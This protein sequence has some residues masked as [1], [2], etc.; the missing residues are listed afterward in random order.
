MGLGYKTG[1]LQQFIT[2]PRSH[3][4]LKPT[5]ISLEEAATISHRYTAIMVAL[6][7]KDGLDLPLEPTEEDKKKGVIV[8]GAA[9]GSGMFAV[10]I[11]KALGYQTILAVASPKQH[12]KLLK[13]GATEVFDR[14]DADLASK[15]QPKYPKLHLGLVAQI[16]PAGWQTMLDILKSTPEH[17]KTSVT[18]IHIIRRVPPSVPPEVTLK[19]TVAFVIVTDP[20]GDLVIAKYL[21][22]LLSAPNFAVPKE[23]QVVSEGSL[24][25]RVKSSLKIA[26]ENTEVSLAIKVN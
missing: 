21:P 13:F 24:L 5:S 23:V 20:K 15:I 11:L 6:L 22:K 12:A 26:G 9:S 4:C 10:Q 19:R 16:D 14:T 17:P 1:S 25:E 18:I 8:W 2:L 3:V 7:F